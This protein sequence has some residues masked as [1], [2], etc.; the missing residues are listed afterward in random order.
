MND[1][2]AELLSRLAFV[3][4]LHSSRR[5]ALFTGVIFPLLFGKREGA[6]AI[7]D[8]IKHALL[9]GSAL[10]TNTAALTLTLAGKDPGSTLRFFE[11][12]EI[13]VKMIRIEP[14][15]G[16]SLSVFLLLFRFRRSNSLERG[17]PN[18]SIR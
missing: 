5:R 7:V 14:R 18:E 4:E 6:A 17:T 8:A 10:F 2:I 3:R 15:P 16:R 9:D 13:R 1:S 12:S 11:A